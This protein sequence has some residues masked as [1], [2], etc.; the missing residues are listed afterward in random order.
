MKILFFAQHYS[1]EEGGGASLATDLSIDLIKKGCQVTFVTAAPSYP[2]GRVFKGYKNFLFKR[3]TNNGVEVI[4]TWSFISSS[5]S[6]WSRIINYATFSV[7][8]FIVGLFLKKPDI[9]FSYSPPLPLGITAWWLSG[10]WNIPWILRVEDLYPDTAI[11]SGILKNQTAI[12]ILKFL[13]KILYNHASHISLISEEFRRNLVNK[14]VKNEKLSVTPIWSD[15]DKF[16]PMEKN[17]QFRHDQGLMGKF[18]LLYS[19]NLGQTSAIED[20]IETA[21]ILKEKPEFVFLIIGEGIKKKYVSQQIEACSLR[22]TLLLP[23]QPLDK[24]PEILSTA[25]VGIVTINSESAHYSLP[26]KIYN[27][28]ASGRPILAVSPE[29]SEIAR[30]I[31]ETGCGINISP[32]NPQV[33][34]ET[35]EKMPHDN[36]SL[37]VMGRKGRSA[38]ENKFL[39]A[40]C[41]SEYYNILLRNL[42]KQ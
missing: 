36:K 3:E 40:N 4:R 32:G 22:N 13:E 12:T 33:L 37:F 15:P 24:L 5:R 11:S 18:I 26:S 23:F 41:V 42:N 39:R 7:S 9:I 14:G 28:M 16:R 25:D 31:I 8:A 38:I 19:G 20:I 29:D 27:I 6:F 10:L 35:I 2:Y 17:T 30:L 21:K 34:A 1:P